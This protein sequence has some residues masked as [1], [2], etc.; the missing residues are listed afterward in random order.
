MT[1]KGLG[2]GGDEED[3]GDEGENISQSS[4]TFPP[5][6]TSPTSPPSPASPSSLFAKRPTTYDHTQGLERQEKE[7]KTNICIHS[8]KVSPAGNNN[9]SSIS[10]RTAALT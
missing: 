6:P 9:V 4:P 5:S 7:K 1:E 10:S 2:D 8:G 3:G